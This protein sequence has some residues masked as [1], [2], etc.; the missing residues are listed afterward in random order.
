[1]SS[2]Q[3]AAAER[4]KAIVDKSR[5]CGGKKR[6]VPPST[7]DFAKQGEEGDGRLIAHLFRD[8]RIYDHNANR[9]YTWEGHY[10]KP[11]DVDS[12]LDEAGPA[13]RG[14]YAKA[15]GAASDD[16]VKILMAAIKRVG[17]LRGLQAAL[18]MARSGKGLATDGKSWDQ[19]RDLFCARNCVINLKTGTPVVGAGPDLMIS[20]CSPTAYSPG[21]QSPRWQSFLDDIFQGDAELVTFVQRIL[22]AALATT[23]H[24][25]RLFPIFVG[26][27]SN[28][29]S[30]MIETVAAV[31]G[32]EY[33]RAV[34]SSLIVKGG[35]YGVKA[36]GA[37]NADAHLLRGLRVA[38]CTEVDTGAQLNV[39]AAKHLT[40]GDAITAREPYA[41]DNT[42]W[43]PTH[44]LVLLANEVPAAAS[45]DQALWGRIKIV[46]FEQIFSPS[47][48]G[49]EKEAD[50]SIRAKLLAEKEGILLWLL[51]GAKLYRKD[52]LGRIPDVVVNATIAAREESDTIRPFLEERVKT[53]DGGKVG[54]REAYAAYVDFVH[55]CGDEPVS[56]KRFGMIMGKKFTRGK[57]RN[58]YRFYEGCHIFGAS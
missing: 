15:L 3:N 38:Y 27:G 46:P 4:I 6:P 12:V 11:D 28:G 56:K 8:R 32:G 54:A 57:D 1:M 10:W 45:A 43:T 34:P 18:Q 25:E 41:R 40:G 47:P 31:L 16:D 36:Q 39:G 13:L 33:C 44:T 50:P 26:P 19:H 23:E 17:K 53:D 51:E 52:G 9:W 2:A 42:T 37:A 30:Q 48:A 55:E 22:G 49:R 35:R 14:E 29:K 5:D 7:L 58:G 20:R 21:A 24:G